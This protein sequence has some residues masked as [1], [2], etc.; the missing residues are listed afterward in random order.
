[1]NGIKRNEASFIHRQVNCISQVLWPLSNV[2]ALLL[3]V[4]FYPV[5]E[6]YLCLLSL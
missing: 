6:V 3:T 5:Y 1:M 2:H 4:D